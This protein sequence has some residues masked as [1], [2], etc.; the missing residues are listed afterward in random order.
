MLADPQFQIVIAMRLK[1]ILL[2]YLLTTPKTFGFDAWSP[3]LDADIALAMLTLRPE[4]RSGRKWQKDFFASR[5]LLPTPA[6]KRLSRANNLNFQALKNVP[7]TPFSPSPLGSLFRP[8]YLSR[9]NKSI[10]VSWRSR[11]ENL[12]GAVP[13]VGGFLRR[14]NLLQRTS[15]GYSAYLC[16]FPLQSIMKEG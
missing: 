1:M 15:V 11:S 9:I 5:D 3:F 14:L 6:S 8:E 12:L 10:E 2:S 7:L 13:K 16:L 4:R